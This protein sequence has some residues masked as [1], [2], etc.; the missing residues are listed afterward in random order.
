M[1]NCAGIFQSCQGENGTVAGS[2][3]GAV[4]KID[5]DQMQKALQVNQEMA[6]SNFGKQKQMAAGPQQWQYEENSGLPDDSQSKYNR[7]PESKNNTM[8]GNT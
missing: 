8:Y 1:G 2:N 4:K 5:R 3:Q 6:S 7:S